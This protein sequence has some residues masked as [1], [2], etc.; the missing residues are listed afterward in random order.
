MKKH[1]KDEI[2][3]P[4][5]TAALIKEA[6]KKRYDYD[7]P[8]HHSGEFYA[9]IKEGRAFVNSL[10]E[11]AFAADLSDSSDSIGDPSSH[12]GVSGEAEELAASVWKSDECFFVLGGTSA[13]NRI[14]ANAILSGGDLVLFDRN[15]HKSAWQGALVQ[16]GAVPVYLASERND[17][18]V[19]G[20]ISETSLDEKEIRKSIRKI[21]PSRA[22]SSRPFRLACLQL[23]TYDGLFINVRHILKKIGH[24]C[25]YILFDGAWAGYENFIPLLKDSAV[26]T[27]SLH[28]SDPGILLTQSV[29]KQ[30]AGFSMTS[31]IQKKDSHIAGTPRYLSHDLLNDTFLMHISTSPYY[32]LIAGL[33]MNA[34][35]HQK[36]SKSLWE[37]AFRT[38]TRL[39]KDLLKHT[40]LFHPFLP[41]EVH[42][43]K[44]AEQKTSS[45]L[46]DSSFFSL[47]TSAQWHGFHDI[48]E[49]SVIL[50][51]CKVL[52]LTGSFSHEKEHS[53]PAPLLSLFLQKNGITPEKSDFY[54][55]LFLTQPGDSRKKNE[56]LLSALK[57]FEESYFRNTPMERFMP[58]ITAK[59]G[60]G[61]MDFCKR[62]H[63]F[64][65]SR[66]AGNL[67][68][69]LFRKEYFPPAPL[70]SREA[71]QRWLRGE[72]APVPLEKAE[73]KISLENILP[74]PPGICCLAAG[75]QWTA[76]IFSYFRFLEDYGKEFPDFQPEIIGVHHNK[77]GDPYVWVL[78][79]EL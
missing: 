11:G 28:G 40:S 26:L 66:N 6:Q 27:F 43:K 74:Y 64:L 35:I 33:E 69:Y 65:I 48:S 75:E 37:K 16:A 34:L 17:S 20:P 63:A 39:K 29:H 58:E 15:N 59:K 57:T 62:Y 23:C 47:D 67:Q 14:A 70:S 18:G 72:G 54:T 60:E 71:H 13:S 42:G 7:T 53:I 5:F 52:I 73:G 46:H 3:L 24:L 50:D 56:Y 61:L 76:P 2:K 9:L 32:P 41:P 8:G 68:K 30:L 49:D 19:I 44:W 38:S 51:P 45:L 78:H 36:A 21:S 1:A 31:Q 79:E 55:L 25:D 10:G 12:E 4:P 22:D 77:E